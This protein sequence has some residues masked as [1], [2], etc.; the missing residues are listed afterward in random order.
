LLGQ[1]MVVLA[2]DGV[3]FAYDYIQEQLHK[4]GP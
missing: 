2:L 3:W 1:A 4:G